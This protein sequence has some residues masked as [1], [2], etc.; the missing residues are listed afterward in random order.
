MQFVLDFFAITNFCDAYSDERCPAIL[1]WVLRNGSAILAAAG[2]AVG[3]QEDFTQVSGV[4]D[5]AQSSVK[6]RQK[7]P[8]PPYGQPDRKKY[9][10]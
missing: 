7:G 6:K 10:F 3:G 8:D 1:E 4:D 9:V 2:P 5:H